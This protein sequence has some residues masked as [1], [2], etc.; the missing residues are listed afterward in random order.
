MDIYALMD[1][2]FDQ[3]ASDLHL[4][5]GRRPVLRVSGGLVEVG[6]APLTPEDTEAMAKELSLIHI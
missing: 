6:D 4:S 2:A 5:V 3:G 1:A